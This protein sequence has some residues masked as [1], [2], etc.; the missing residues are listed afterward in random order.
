MSRP[1]TVAHFWDGP[2]MY[3]AFA[4]LQSAGFHP[5]ATEFFHATVNPILYVGLG[6]V[7][8][9]VP[10]QEAVLAAEL[11]DRCRKE[12]GANG[13]SEDIREANREDGLTCPRC[14]TADYFRLKSWIFAAT[15]YLVLG[16]YAPLATG[17]L[18]CRSCGHIWRDREDAA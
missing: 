8:I 3:A 14:D 1:V 2:E 15:L 5:C 7:R 6:G 16:L 4:A 12:Q 17:K 11:I 9:V 18:L 10:E 13:G